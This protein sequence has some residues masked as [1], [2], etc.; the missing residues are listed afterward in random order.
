M[1]NK[2]KI[3]IVFNSYTLIHTAP[4]LLNHE[5]YRNKKLDARKFHKKFNMLVKKFPCMGKD[6]FW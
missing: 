2:I 4:N 6:N 1:T 5:L 3:Y